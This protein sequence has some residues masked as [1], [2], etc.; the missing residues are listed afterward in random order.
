MFP[1]FFIKSSSLF[2]SSQP[3]MLPMTL[4]SSFFRMSSSCKES[5]S[6]GKAS[7]HGK[8]FLIKSR[9]SI[10]SLLV[11]VFVFQWQSVWRF[12]CRLLDRHGSR[13]LPIREWLVDFFGTNSMGFISREGTPIE[14]TYFRLQEFEGVTST[15]KPSP[16]F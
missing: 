3:L 11:L 6:T 14:S 1:K 5:W 8:I 10:T 16:G 9:V 15:V 12:E 4:C 7:C 13:L 2:R